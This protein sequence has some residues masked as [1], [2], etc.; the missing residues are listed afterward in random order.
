MKQLFQIGA[1][2]IGRGFIARLFFNNGY[3]IAFSDVNQEFVNQLNSQK[4]YNVHVVDV[5][6]STDLISNVS[7]IHASNQVDFNQ[8]FLKSDIITLSVG[9][10]VLQFVAKNI[11]LAIIEKANNQ[12]TKK[13]TIIAC[14]NY[15]GATSYLKTLIEAHLSEELQT[16]MNT[17]I[18]F[19]D[20]AVDC[21][22]PPS[23]ADGIDVSVEAFYE[24]VLDK[25]KISDADLL[26]CPDIIFTDKIMSYIERKLFTLNAAHALI[27]YTGYPL[28]YKTIFEAISDS[29]IEQLTTDYMQKNGEILCA[30]HQ[31]DPQLHTEYIHK[32]LKRFRNPHLADELTRV[33]RSLIRKVNSG[34]RLVAP[35]TIA[36]AFDIDTTLNEKALAVAL[37]YPNQE[38]P[39]VK[40]ILLLINERGS[41]ATL[42]FLTGLDETVLSRV[43]AAMNKINEEGITWIFQS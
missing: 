25:T 9:V 31:F 38:D 35:I 23:K 34:E 27:A 36:K 26:R 41:D 42:A 17:V 28:G 2:N 11:A 15:V 24:L 4:A 14:E 33:G 22:V 32:I 19:P 5:V 43:K 3:T 1:G 40:A 18:A 20:C 8:Q 30:K 29:R 12:D 7:A 6:A 37:S 13:Q 16:F 21:I 10:S 39:D